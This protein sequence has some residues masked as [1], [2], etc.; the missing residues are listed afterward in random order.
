[1]PELYASMH[2]VTANPER[3]RRTV[4]A[5]CVDSPAGPYDA[6]GSEIT[7]A[8]DP[9]VAR[10]YADALILRIAESYFGA[11][12]FWRWEPAGM[13]P[14]GTDTFLSDPLIGTPTIWAKGG[15]GVSTHHNS[16]D[17]PDHVD[18]RSMRDLTVLTA[19][20]LYYLASAS[21]AEVPWLAQITAGRG[22]ENIL[23]A[24]RPSLEG[25]EAAATAE[26]LA[27]ELRDGLAQIAYSAER[28]REAVLSTLRLAAP[29]SRRSL[30]ASL[31]PTIEGLRRFAAAQSDHLTETVNR[32][33]AALGIAVPVKPLAP[34]QLTE[35]SRMIV[36]RKRVGTVTLDDLPRDQWEGQPSASWNGTLIAALDWCDGRRNLAE[37]IRLTTLERGPLRVDLVGWFRFLAKHGYVELTAAP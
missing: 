10:S 9:D 21:D 18:P 28:D 33:A 30:G 20:Y 8:L 31:A 24:A 22:Y 14:G 23:R 4:A 12:R 37:V 25:A 26:A 27:R 15:L 5:M 29:E 16:A 35:A 19:A 2:Y 34:T 36:K 32:R 6:E 11:R 17:T 13:G 3:M 7:F 1:M